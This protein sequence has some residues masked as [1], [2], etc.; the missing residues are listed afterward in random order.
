MD[1]SGTIQVQKVKNVCKCLQGG[2]QVCVRQKKNA[3]NME[4]GD[5]PLEM[6]WERRTKCSL[7]C[8]VLHLLLPRA[9]ISSV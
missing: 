7:N 5:K 8:H 6:I 1:F 3:G 2:N 9:E 4:V